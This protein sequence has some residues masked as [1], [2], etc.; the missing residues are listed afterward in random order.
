MEEPVNEKSADTRLDILEALTA[1]W[2][3]VLMAGAAAGVIAGVIALVYL[4]WI[5]P[6]RR[7]SVLPFRPNF[8]GG[9]SGLYPNGLPFSSTDITAPE[10][11]DQVFA[12]N[13]LA[14][15]CARDLFRAGFFVD[16]QSPQVI[17]LDAEYQS[18]LAEARLTPVDREKIVAEYNSKRQT[19]PLS[20]RL[21]FIQPPQCS[22]LPK[23]VVAK[24]L[25]DVLTVW[26][27]DAELKRGALG[28]RVPLLSPAALDWDRSDSSRIIRADR[29]RNALRQLQGN[30]RQVQA[31]SGA[32]LVHIGED[33]LGFMEVGN[34]FEDLVQSRLDPL[35][36]S[37]GRNLGV[38]SLE[39]INETLSAAQR[40]YKGAA[41]RVEG[42]RDALRQYSESRSP[43]VPSRSAAAADAPQ[44]LQ[45]D[46]TFLDRMLDMS[47]LNLE[48]RQKVT[49]ELI[50][51]GV[52]AIQE[53]QDMEYYSHLRD[54]VQSGR[55]S[56]LSPAE[57][58]A[59]MAEV[60]T[61]GKAV[62]R[63]FTQLYDEFSRVS[64]RPAGAMFQFEGPVNQTTERD[65]G[66]RGLV[67][68]TVSATAGAMIVVLAYSVIRRRWFP[69]LGRRPQ[70]T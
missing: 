21:M 5:Q 48:F 49:R 15:F 31:V 44:S 17:F 46:V 61:D 13:G 29:I 20:Y 64:F 42:L 51:A 33:R 8:R 57:I 26:A 3:M 67:F 12:A 6:T 11:V 40:R 65:F 38:D 28:I 59:R 36:F 58:D 32:D 18:R 19:I 7:V 2:R 70:T 30:V 1:S 9:I 37:A 23:A 63:L 60:V 56:S 14:D 39:Y 47:K 16:Q 41:E 45:F 22:A 53:Q 4:F 69:T 27:N 66:F 35:V 62:A 68:V 43:T 52:V 54:I 50:Q 10:I 55:V 25:V 24:S 34:R